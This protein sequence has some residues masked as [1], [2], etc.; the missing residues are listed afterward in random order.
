MAV[1]SLGGIPVAVFGFLTG[2]V[3]RYLS[4]TQFGWLF[5]ILYGM[6]SAYASYLVLRSYLESRIQNLVWNHTELADL[7]FESTVSARKLFWIHASNLAL[8]PQGG[9]DEFFSDQTVDDAGAAGQ[10]A[11]E[12][13]D[14]DIAL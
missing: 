13:F 10:E 12:F 8:V 4:T 2:D 5:K 14:I 6:A 1:A 11:G 7:S 3:F 9:L